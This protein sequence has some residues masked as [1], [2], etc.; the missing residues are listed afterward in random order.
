M[1]SKPGQ[2]DLARSRYLALQR[3][4]RNERRSTAEM[5]QLY[6]L[7][8][9]LR[10]LGRSPHNERLVLKGGVLMA[11]FEPCLSGSDLQRNVG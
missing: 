11:A 1:K 4:A 8:G 2:A 3:L 6:V 7:E 9:F 5:L 10:R